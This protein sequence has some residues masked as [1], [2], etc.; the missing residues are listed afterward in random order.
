MTELRSWAACMTKAANIR[1][2]LTVILSQMTATEQACTFLLITLLHVVEM[3]R[4]FDKFPAVALSADVAGCSVTVLR[5]M[6]TLS[7]LPGHIAT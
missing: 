1:P 5:R 6:N 2:D 4:S 7:R 3:V